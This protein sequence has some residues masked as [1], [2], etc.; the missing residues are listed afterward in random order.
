[1]LKAFVAT[2]LLPLYAARASQQAKRQIDHKSTKT[3]Q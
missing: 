1:M 3:S 2:L